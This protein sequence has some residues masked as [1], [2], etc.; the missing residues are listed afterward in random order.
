MDTRR[1]FPR[2]QIAKAIC[3]AEAGATLK[4]WDSAAWTRTGTR[5]RQRPNTEPT[6]TGTRD[7]ISIQ[8][9]TKRGFNTVIVG[10]SSDN[11]SKMWNQ[12]GNGRP[13][14][15]TYGRPCERKSGAGHRYHTCQQNSTTD[16]YPDREQMGGKTYGLMYGQ[17][18]TAGGGNR[19]TPCMEQRRASG[20]IRKVDV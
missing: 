15:K 18:R 11:H 5:R 17:A 3:A 20:E 2:S 12:L 14:P 13:F 9:L 1:T 4:K 8:E 19:I 6:A 16:N 7:Q 10:I